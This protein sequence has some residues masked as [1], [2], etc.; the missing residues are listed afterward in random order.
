M[1]Q[2][3]GFTLI[4]LMVVVII[5]GILAALGLASLTKRMDAAK[6]D[7]A[8]TVFQASRVAQEKLSAA[9]SVV[10][11]ISKRRFRRVITKTS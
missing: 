11:W 3:E 7:E 10:S 9:F 8:L 1:T 6:A 5:M 4:E 2:Q